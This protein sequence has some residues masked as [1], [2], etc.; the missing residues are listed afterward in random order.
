MW[1]VVSVAQKCCF[2]D[3]VENEQPRSDEPDGCRSHVDRLSAHTDMCSIGNAMETAEN[4]AETIRTRQNGLRTQNS[5]NTI[6]I[7][8][9]ELPGRWRKVSIGGGDVY[10]PF[11]VPIVIP[12][13]RIV[14]G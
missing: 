9:P 11:N 10:V 2:A 12:T 13:W 7:A 14:F 3:A 1:S 4:E 8:M 6:N 5:P